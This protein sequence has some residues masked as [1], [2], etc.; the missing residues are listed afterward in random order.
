MLGGGIGIARP[1]VSKRSIRLRTVRGQAPAARAA[2]SGVCPLSAA[3]TGRSRPT[4]LNRAFFRM[5]IRSSSKR[6]RCRNHSFPDPDLMDKL[7]RDD[8]QARKQS[9]LLPV[10]WTGT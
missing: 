3:K 10:P 7:L 8:S 9:G 6:P 4:G 5:F 1:S 2:A